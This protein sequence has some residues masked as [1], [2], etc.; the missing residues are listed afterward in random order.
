MDSMVSLSCVTVKSM[1]SRASWPTIFSDAEAGGLVLDLAV[2]RQAVGAGGQFGLKLIQLDFLVAHFSA[3]PD[4]QR[5]RVGQA[6]GKQLNDGGLIQLD[7]RA[8]PAGR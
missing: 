1:R 3:H 4:I 8:G 6:A 2:Q 5:G 7:L